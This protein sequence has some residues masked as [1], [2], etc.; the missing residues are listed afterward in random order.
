MKSSPEQ[1]GDDVVMC[2]G[3]K[4]KN[5]NSQTNLSR[6]NN[7]LLLLVA[8]ETNLTLEYPSP[9]QAQVRFHL[10]MNITEKN[11]AI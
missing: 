9:L 11:R 1:P 3:K 6:R 10:K 7:R 4:S 5:N 2:S 8:S